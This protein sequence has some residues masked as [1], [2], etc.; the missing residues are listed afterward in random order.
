MW[1]WYMASTRSSVK[2]DFTK[3]FVFPR[4]IFLRLLATKRCIGPR[5]TKTHGSTLCYKLAYYALLTSSDAVAF[6]LLPVDT[7]STS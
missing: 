7:L 2:L 1:L 5:D 6:A 4:E 3:A